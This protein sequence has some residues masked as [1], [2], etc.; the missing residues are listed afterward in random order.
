MAK[1][2]PIHV[3]YPTILFCI[4]LQRWRK[5]DVG[6]EPVKHKC[7]YE[8]LYT[9]FIHTKKKKQKIPH[10]WMVREGKEKCDVGKVKDLT[11]PDCGN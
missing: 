9:V 1:I 3:E 2:I 6:K 7:A 10:V 5:C 8:T 11:T 4:P